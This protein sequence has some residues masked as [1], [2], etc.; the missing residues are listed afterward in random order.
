MIY[1]VKRGFL[2]IFPYSDA[3]M[4]MEPDSLYIVCSFELE[5]IMCKTIIL[6]REKTVIRY[7]F[8]PLA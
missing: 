3:E 6:A 7:C 1:V 5:Y 4:G 8:E 2:L